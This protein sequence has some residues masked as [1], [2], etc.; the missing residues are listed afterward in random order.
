M[1]TGDPRQRFQAD[2]M[3]SISQERLVVLLYQRAARDL[4]AARQAILDG[5]LEERH[6]QLVHAQQIIEELAYAVRPD[7]WSGGDGLI[8]LYDFILDRLVKAN[9][10]ADVRPL[11]EAAQLIGELSAAWSDAYVSLQTES[12]TA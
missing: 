9:V 6:N 3:Q 4:V 8:A 1:R 2:G 5:R 11:D 12:A 10:T 7:V